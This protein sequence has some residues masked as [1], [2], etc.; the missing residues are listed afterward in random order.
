M[1]QNWWD[2]YSEVLPSPAAR[3]YPLLGPSGPIPG[4][5]LGLGPD[6]LY[7]APRLGQAQGGGF[8][9]SYLAG[10]PMLG[11]FRGSSPDQAGPIGYSQPPLAGDQAGPLSDRRLAVQQAAA[12][13]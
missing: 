3:P 13:I 9:P 6:P 7:G 10:A 11:Q 1:P 4:P 12:A 8:D 5:P 2:I